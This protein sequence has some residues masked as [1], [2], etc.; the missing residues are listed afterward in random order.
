MSETSPA[1]DSGKNLGCD[2]PSLLPS[3]ILPAPPN[4]PSSNY[5]VNVSSI[6]SPPSSGTSIVII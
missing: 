1:I 2:N 4:P 6:K 5:N 3:L